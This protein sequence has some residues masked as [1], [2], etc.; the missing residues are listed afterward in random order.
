MARKSVPTLALDL[1]DDTPAAA[2]E[3]P[4][5]ATSEPG[6]C[7][8]GDSP[9]VTEPAGSVTTPPL[10]PY[11]YH[12]WPHAC[13]FAAAARRAGHTH[14]CLDPPIDETKARQYDFDALTRYAN[15]LLRGIAS[16]APRMTVERWHEATCLVRG[17]SN[18]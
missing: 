13:V 4:E 3:S 15:G 8:A 11:F 6:P 17:E 12:L 5:P 9:S 18:G 14:P 2:P 10:A 1:W 16:D 7:T